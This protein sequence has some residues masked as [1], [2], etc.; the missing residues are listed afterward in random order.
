MKRKRLI[1]RVGVPSFV[2]LTGSVLQTVAFW[3]AVKKPTLYARKIEGLG[4]NVLSM[5]IVTL[6]AAS[7]EHARRT[8]L[9]TMKS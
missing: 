9:V 4:R 2:M 6:G 8:L 1:Q 3:E 5:M 7:S